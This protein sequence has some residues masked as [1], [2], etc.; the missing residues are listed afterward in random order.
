ML[1]LVLI[2]RKEISFQ[3]SPSPRNEGV[4]CQVMQTWAWND[5]T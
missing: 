2:I 1:S 5:C 3:Q 4:F